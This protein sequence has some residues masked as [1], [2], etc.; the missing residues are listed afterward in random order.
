MWE[1]KWEVDSL[2]YPMLLTWAYYARTHD[3]RIFS[4]RLHDAMRRIVATY[5]CEQRHAECSHY[6]Y[7]GTPTG[8]VPYT[9]MIWG[10]FRP[11]D[12][13]VTYGFNIP[14]QMGALIALEDLGTLAVIGFNDTQLAAQAAA[15]HV[16]VAAGIDRY[17][18]VYNFRY[19]WIYAFEVD[20]RG[21]SIEMDDANM[22][23]L[24]SIPLYGFLRADDPRYLATRRFVLSKDN[25]YYYEGKYATGLGSPHTPKG[26]IWPLG[27]I[28][29][30]LTALTAHETLTALLTL[31][32]TDGADGLI[33]ESFDP[34][35][36]E[37]Y[38]RA[39]FGWGNAMYAEL[40][41]RS[42]A[43][44]ASPSLW[45]QTVTVVDRRM[46]HTPQIVGTLAQ[47]EN[48][49]ELISAFERDV[50]MQALRLGE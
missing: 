37:H 24:L 33:H 46:P 42:A 25:P 9:G 8:G 38:T 10:A 15:L 47:I 30:G 26:W 12:D 29:R 44:F 31:S 34:N 20:G 48:I 50:P 41:F 18:S 19:G 49:A 21:R 36:F 5:A 3:R 23:N 1:H 45:P 22:P 40:L 27:I 6:H 28:T 13:S 4:S 43:G 7:P 11:S 16:A 14:Q 32:V 17:G 39:D 2:T 35:A